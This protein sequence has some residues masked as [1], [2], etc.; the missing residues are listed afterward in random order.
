MDYTRLG[1][2]AQ[3]GAALQEV[4]KEIELRMPIMATTIINSMRVKAFFI[5]AARQFPA[6]PIL[7]GFTAPRKTPEEKEKP[8]VPRRVFSF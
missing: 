1:P 8:A 7:A 5:A 4:K 2:K 6:G 3:S